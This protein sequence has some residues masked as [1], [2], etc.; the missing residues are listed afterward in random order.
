MKYSRST[1][2]KLQRALQLV[3]IAAPATQVAAALLGGSIAGEVGALLG[4]VLV[5]V[6]LLPFTELVGWW[7]DRHTDWGS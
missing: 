4:M 5:P 3:V 1:N 6:A 7:I 2:H